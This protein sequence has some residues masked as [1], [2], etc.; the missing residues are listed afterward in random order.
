MLITSSAVAPSW[1]LCM[2]MSLFQHGVSHLSI[3]FL[4]IQARSMP[5]AAPPSKGGSISVGAGGSSG[6]ISDG[7]SGGS[8]GG[9]GGGG[10]VGCSCSCS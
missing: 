1:P 2:G 5:S 7:S 3:A 10:G 4:L 9:G 6:D 8:G